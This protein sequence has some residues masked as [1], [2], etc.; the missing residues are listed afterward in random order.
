MVFEERFTTSVFLIFLNRLVKTEAG[1]K[2]YLI[3]DRHSVHKSKAVQKWL[4]THAEKL[5]LFPLPP[6]S[7]EVNPD[8]LL[9]RDLKNNARRKQHATTLREMTAAGRSF[10]RD[11]QRKPTIVKRY[12]T[13][14]LLAYSA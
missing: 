2:V 9:N 14:P 3:V 8:E 7:P 6:Y 13:T 12:F 1:R 5:S 4:D 10:M 11:R